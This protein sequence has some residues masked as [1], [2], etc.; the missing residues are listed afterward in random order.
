[1]K[2]LDLIPM[3]LTTITDEIHIKMKKCVKRQG[4]LV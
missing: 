1:M 3:I 4:V 2:T